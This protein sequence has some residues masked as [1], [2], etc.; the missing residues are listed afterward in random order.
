MGLTVASS[1]VY[2]LPP[3][4]SF[5]TRVSFESRYGMCVPGSPFDSSSTTFPSVLRLPLMKRASLRRS[6]VD[7]LFFRRSDPARFRWLCMV[8]L[9]SAS[10]VTFC[11]TVMVNTVWE[12]DDTSFRG[13]A[14]V[15]R[16]AIPAFR[17]AIASSLP[18]TGKYVR[19]FT[20]VCPLASSMTSRCFAPSPS[21]PRLLALDGR[22][23]RLALDGRVRAEVGREGGRAA[24]PARNA[25]AAFPRSSTWSRYSSSME[26]CTVIS[27]EASRFAFSA[28]LNSSSITRGASPRNSCLPVSSPKMLRVSG[29]RSAVRSAGPPVAAAGSGALT[30]TSSP[31]PS[32][33]RPGRRR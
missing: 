17:M 1:V 32:G 25:S 21:L 22:E 8:L 20:Y 31:T 10:P 11:T 2:E 30:C 6:P 7:S 33:R 4:E 18:S 19:S 13:V 3:S 26:T 29:R 14:A 24:P 28:C 9:S 23:P 16:T 15:R 5:S 27:R 12:R